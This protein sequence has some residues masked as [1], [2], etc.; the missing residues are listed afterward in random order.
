M[1]KH[2]V[3]QL[4]LESPL[5]FLTSCTVTCDNVLQSFTVGTSKRVLCLLPSRE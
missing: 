3:D 4:I 1:V 5:Y 2:V